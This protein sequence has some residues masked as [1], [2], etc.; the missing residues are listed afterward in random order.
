[1][2]LLPSLIWYMIQAR[3]SAAQRSLPL[4]A[5]PLSQGCPYHILVYTTMSSSDYSDSDNEAP[6]EVTLSS[7]KQSRL[8]AERDAQEAQRE[9]VLR[10][11]AK[12][13]NV[14]QRDPLTRSVLY[15]M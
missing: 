9:C 15:C 2:L 12:P 6:E 14:E 3:R 7:A 1:M 4:L 13:Q 5:P 8:Q 10:F 11:R